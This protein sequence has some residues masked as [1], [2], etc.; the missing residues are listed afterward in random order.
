MIDKKNNQLSVSDADPE[1]PFL[2][3]TYNARKLGKPR[4]RHYLFT[5]GISRSASET[6]GRQQLMIQI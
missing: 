4:F 5:I 3:S 2:G 6:D 1:I